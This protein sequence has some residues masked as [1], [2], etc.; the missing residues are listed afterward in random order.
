MIHL[1]PDTW[2]RLKELLLLLIE[3]RTFSSESGRESWAW[4]RMTQPFSLV[5]S[6][7]R[8]FSEGTWYHSLRECKGF[9]SC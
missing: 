5:L 3:S 7:P 9:R 6:T 1:V 2:V 8:S 4:N